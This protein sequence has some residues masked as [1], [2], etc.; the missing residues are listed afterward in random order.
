MARLSRSSL[1]F[2]FATVL[3]AT[4]VLLIGCP[5]NTVEGTGGHFPDYG[6]DDPDCPSDSC[7]C[8]PCACEGQVPSYCHFQSGSSSAHAAS[9]STTSTGTS[10]NDGGIKDAG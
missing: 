8:N 3:L 9:S 10:M 1:A 6:G 4:P 2:A 5:D 7:D